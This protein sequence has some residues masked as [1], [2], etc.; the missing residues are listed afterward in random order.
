MPTDFEAEGLLEGVGDERARRARLELLQTLEEEGF[1]PEEL[2]RAAAEDR[3]VLLPLERVLE[4]EGRRYTPEEVAEQ[5]GVDVEF[6]GDARR[7]MG[8]P[9]P[10]PGERILTEEDLELARRAKR[11]LDAGIGREA[12]LEITRVMSQAMASVAAAF[13]TTF[14]EAL[15]RPGD[16]ERDLGLRYAD[17]MRELGPLAAPA[18]QQMLNLRMREQ[19]RQAVVGQAELRSGHLPGAQWIT[20]AFVDI[21]GFTSLGEEVPPDELGSVVGRFERRVEEAVSP[22]VRLVKTIGDAAMLASAE[23][24]PLVRT[25]LQLVDGSQADEDG[26]VLR[27][28]VAAGEAITR[29][30]DWYGRPVNLAS[31]L[32][33]FARRGSVVASREVREAAG[34]ELAWS[35]VGR[36]RLKGVRGEVEVY[37]VRPRS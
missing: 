22:P 34:E 30:G 9:R 1:T 7:A 19:I 12:F 11:L 2:R 25:A 17:A 24:A 14:G 33:A 21:V 37:R 23:A 18:L 4:G 3:L 27:S 10:E 13:A 15:L 29:A 20:V 8:A 36:R 31:R 5:T 6:L 26:P 32:T 28:G 35:L 16:T